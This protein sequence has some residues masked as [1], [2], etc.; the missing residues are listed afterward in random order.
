M[1]L[2]VETRPSLDLG[3][4]QLLFEIPNLAAA[5]FAVHP[6]GERFVVARSVNTGLSTSQVNIV[7]N[8]HQELL[9]R[10]PVP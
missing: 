2:T 3:A 7:L 6:D 5:S 10:V 9:E 1:A 8:W 4:P